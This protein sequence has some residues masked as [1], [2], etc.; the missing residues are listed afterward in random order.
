M[1]KES[2]GSWTKDGPESKPCDGELKTQNEIKQ[3]KWAG[4]R[5][6]SEKQANWY[7]QVKHVGPGEEDQTGY[8]GED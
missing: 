2:V 1:K 5:R 4:P 7:S 8:A 6:K 3:A